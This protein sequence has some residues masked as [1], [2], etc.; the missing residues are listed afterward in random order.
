MHQM[1]SNKVKELKEIKR[2]EIINNKH[3]FV[4][5]TRSND[6]HQPRPCRMV[7]HRVDNEISCTN[8]CRPTACRS[9]TMR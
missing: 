3:D 5:R 6:V 4:V 1:S 7:D 9:P 2:G 8:T